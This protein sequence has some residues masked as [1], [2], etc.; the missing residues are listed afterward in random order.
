MNK[1]FMN[2]VRESVILYVETSGVDPVTK[3]EIYKD[4][5]RESDERLL[6]LLITGKKNY[7]AIDFRSLN[8]TLQAVK[9]G[10]SIMHEIDKVLPVVMLED[11]P[12]DDPRV[13]RGVLGKAAAGAKMAGQKAVAGAKWA[14]Q[15]ATAGAKMAGGKG[16]D[17]LKAIGAKS[18]AATLAQKILRL[19]P[20]DVGKAQAVGGIGVTVLVALLLYASYK[21]YQRYKVKMASS[22]DRLTGEERQECMKKVNERAKEARIADL[23]KSMV[24]CKK[25]NDP[26]KCTEMIKAKISKLRKQ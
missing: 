18:G 24:S 11:L 10:P 22:C 5:M 17:A 26:K 25:S 2:F 4:L 13:R 16:L 3:N 23:Q 19:K 1:T 9:M 7:K 6:S 8:E 12:T 14:G 15:K 21:L 20:E